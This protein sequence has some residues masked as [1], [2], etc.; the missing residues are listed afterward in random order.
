MSIS[1][2]IVPDGFAAAAFDVPSAQANVIVGSGDMLF[3]KSE[4]PL[5]FRT[6]MDTDTSAGEAGMVTVNNAPRG[7]CT[8]ICP[9]FICCLTSFL[10]EY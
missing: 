7:I 9:S 6:S 8:V 10:L 3:S 1:V 4:K 5:S 2:P